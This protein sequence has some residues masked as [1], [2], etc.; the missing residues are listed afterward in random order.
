MIYLQYSNSPFSLHSCTLHTVIA[1]KFSQ[2]N[3]ENEEYIFKRQVSAERTDWV[4][5]EQ[6]L[7]ASVGSCPTKFA[8]AQMEKGNSG[9]KRE[10]H[11]VCVL[12]TRS[13]QK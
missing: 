7:K 1:A 5:T 6:K 4:C 10:K 11:R 12:G 9:L 2:L 3:S 8:K 13:S